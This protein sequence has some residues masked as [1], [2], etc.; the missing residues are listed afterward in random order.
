MEKIFGIG[1]PNTSQKLFAVFS[2]SRTTMATWQIFFAS[3]GGI[4]TIPFRSR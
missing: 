3:I 4:P 1:T 2:M